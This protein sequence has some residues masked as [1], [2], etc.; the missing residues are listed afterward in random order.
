VTRH[1]NEGHENARHNKYS[2]KI[3]YITI[4]CAFFVSKVETTQLGKGGKRR[5]RGSRWGGK[6]DRD[7]NEEEDSGEEG[8][9]RK[10]RDF[11]GLIKIQLLRPC[12]VVVVSL[13]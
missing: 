7:G 4:Q 13:S 5:K 10:G 12:S 8:K 2:M 1:E 3:D 6:G 11:V 9:Q